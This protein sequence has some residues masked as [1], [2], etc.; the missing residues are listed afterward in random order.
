MGLGVFN[1]NIYTG[2]C[3]KFW[4][5]LPITLLYINA[6]TWCD[7]SDMTCLKTSNVNMTTPSAQMWLYGLFMITADCQFYT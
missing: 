3:N 7:I 5:R 4:F 1:I 6:V 2:T